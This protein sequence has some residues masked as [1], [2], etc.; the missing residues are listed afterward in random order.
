MTDK[1]LGNLLADS[2][3][4]FWTAHKGCSYFEAP[5]PTKTLMVSHAQLILR[6]RVVEPV[7]SATVCQGFKLGDVVGELETEL[8][9]YSAL[10][11]EVLVIWLVDPVLQ[12]IS[13]HAAFADLKR[14]HN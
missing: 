6:M 14:Q 10:V 2:D 8:Q 12:N 7:E 3:G 9:D 4:V 13:K 11:V 5:N 1:E